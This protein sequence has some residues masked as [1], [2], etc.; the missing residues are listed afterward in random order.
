MK[1]SIYNHKQSEYL[2]IVSLKCLGGFKKYTQIMWVL[3]HFGLPDK[4]FC[5]WTDGRFGGLHC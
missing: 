2:A 5:F 3:E 1:V 4:L